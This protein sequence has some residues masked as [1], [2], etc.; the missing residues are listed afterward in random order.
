MQSP[1]ISNLFTLTILD[2]ADELETQFA[3][4]YATYIQS[5]LN[6]P[7]SV[8]LS[9]LN[10]LLHSNISTQN[11][12]TPVTFSQNN[13]PNSVTVEICNGLVYAYIASEALGI[14]ENTILDHIW[15]LG[16]FPTLLH[17]LQRI[18]MEKYT[19]L[20]PE[21][22]QSFWDLTAKM[23][24]L[25]TSGEGANLI[26]ILI[27]Y[28]RISSWTAE[29]LLSFFESNFNWML[30]QDAALQCSVYVCLRL[31]PY[32]IRGIP[33]GSIENQ[34][35]PL[36]T[37][38][39]MESSFCINA[40]QAR[41]DAM[42]SIGRDFIR[43]MHYAS[44]FVPGLKELYNQ[45]LNDPKVFQNS[46]YIGSAQILSTPTPRRVLIS[47]LTPDM[48]RQ[49][50]FLMS[51]VK[52]GNQ[53]RY[54]GWFAQM[55]FSNP[56]SQICIIDLIRFTNIVYHPKVQSGMVYR[57]G[58]LGWLLTSITVEKDSDHKRL[59]QEALVACIFDW[60]CYNPKKDNCMNI[61]PSLLLMVYSIPK[62][63]ELTISVIETILYY[64]RRGDENDKDI[65][66]DLYLMSRDTIT[67][68]IQTAMYKALQKK[69]I[70]SIAPLILFEKMPTT[71]VE[72]MKNIFG[73]VEQQATQSQQNS[74]PVQMNNQSPNTLNQN[75][76]Q[77]S[78]TFFQPPNQQ[79]IINPL[80]QPQLIN[81]QTNSQLPP[82]QHTQV[83]N[84]T[85]QQNESEA[86]NITSQFQTNPQ[87]QQ[88]QEKSIIKE[89]ILKFI[90]PTSN[91]EIDSFINYFNPHLNDLA[92]H[93]SSMYHNGRRNP[94]NFAKAQESLIQILEH[95]ENERDE[96]LTDGNIQHLG[97]FLIE[98]LSLELN[99]NEKDKKSHL[100]LILTRAPETLW[101]GMMVHI[102]RILSQ[103]NHINHKRSKSRFAQL[104]KHMHQYDSSLGYKI[105]SYCIR[106]NKCFLEDVQDLIL[107]SPTISTLDRRSKDILS[108]VISTDSNRPQNP[109]KYFSFYEWAIQIRRQNDTI[110]AKDIFFND[111][112]ICARDGDSLFLIFLPLI[113]KYFP[114][115]YDSEGKV[116]LFRIICTSLLPDQLA[117]LSSLTLCGRLNLFENGI[118]IKTISGILKEII[119]LDYYQRLCGWEILLSEID[120]ARSQPDFKEE[121]PEFGEENPCTLLLQ[122][123]QENVLQNERDLQRKICHLFTCTYLAKRYKIS[124]QL[125][126]QLL[127]LNPA[128]YGF[129]PSTFIYQWMYNQTV[130]KGVGVYQ[131]AQHVESLLCK[132]SST[133]SESTDT[134]DSIENILLNLLYLRNTESRLLN[135]TSK[136]VK[137]D[138]L[139]KN[140]SSD[141]SEKE[142]S[143]SVI[144]FSSMGINQ[145]LKKLRDVS[146]Y[147]NLYH[148]HTLLSRLL[149]LFP[150]V[151]LTILKE[152]KIENSLENLKKSRKRK[153]SNEDTNPIMNDSPV[154]IA[155]RKQK[156]RR[157]KKSYSETSEEEE[158]SSEEESEIESDMEDE[159]SEESN[160]E[161]DDEED[162]EDDDDDEENSEDDEEESSE[163]E[164]EE[165]E[166]DEKK[167]P[168][169]RGRKPKQNGD[170]QDEND[171][172]T[173]RKTRSKNQSDKNDD[174]GSKSKSSSKQSPTK[175][176]K[177]GVQKK[178]KESDKDENENKRGG[179]RRRGRK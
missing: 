61:E 148:I 126:H 38:G 131:I 51:K 158:D 69:V 25:D 49:I 157:I 75:N 150:G 47:A 29:K 67:F 82:I 78:P 30:K 101:F 163:E 8:Q 161:D 6:V 81:Q 162:G 1:K 86:L 104:L 110:Q 121:S 167:E 151:T 94:V 19:K 118:N 17:S 128:D 72:Q 42:I 170:K 89:D 129:F 127:Q 63:V 112:R 98:I 140:D 54:Q 174:K 16:E 179:T 66:I 135:D 138:K 33:T 115:Y 10:Q 95:F 165:S 155:K 99:M 57:W 55:Y 124:E 130:K 7:A 154:P 92:N 74:I 153:R 166:E 65:S 117:D 136:V 177:N 123:I 44:I 4:S 100:N 146:K 164:G 56:G 41:F 23:V 58:V 71:L 132:F 108:N 52:W 37:M 122:L 13:P 88:K 70:T 59:H 46:S 105:L 91:P 178:G 79:N 147:K 139:E 2:D 18:A 80:V 22:R 171:N 62:Y 159:D 73:N 103:P 113:T 137:I 64:T 32:H 83:I 116:E 169:K 60:L 106:R 160:G 173:G 43:A 21:V 133:E 102:H 48:E 14:K 119:K 134:F 172:K 109:E 35:M 87:Q 84:S 93:T 143:N 9:S 176:R 28:M 90:Q 76:I 77:T 85:I 156:R 125:T 39:Q 11:S 111:M 107:T 26:E 145:N 5:L 168:K 12:S 149:D 40:I 175:S 68:N 144:L 96:I 36:S 142:S 15:S 3:S 34:A 24:L 152:Q 20:L 27:R 141:K 97:H 114:S 45:M 50:F 53:R 120:H 31:V